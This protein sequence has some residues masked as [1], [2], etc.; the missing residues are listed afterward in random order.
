MSNGNPIP[1]SR[2]KVIQLNQIRE[3]PSAL[4]PVN[5]KSEKYE[6]LVD[7]VRKNGIMNPIVVREVKDRN[8]GEIYYGLVDG[9]H[10]YNAAQ[11][12]GLTEVAVNV[13]DIDEAEVLE[14]QILANLH[15]VDTRPVEYTKQLMRILSSNLLM[16]ISE[17]ASKLSVNP[18][19][20][21]ER[22]GLIKL[23]E[24]IANLV[25]E[26]KITLSNSYSLARLPFEEQSAYV[27]RAMTMQ[28]KEFIPT[29]NARVKEIRNAKRQG[30]DPSAQ[31]FVP[32]PHMRRIGEINE[33]LEKK[34]VVRALI[35]EVKPKTAEDAFMLGL[36]WVRH[37]DPLSIEAQK[38]ADADRKAKEEQDKAERKRKREEE[39]AEKAREIAETVTL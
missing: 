39:K 38:Q 4:R 30:R 11:D 25:D 37:M 27:E 23:D 7:S 18:G 31:T 28:P 8:T 24:K 5:K 36:E 19:W 3:N 29:V 34:A 17:L 33:E 10:R 12:A 13:I 2:P 6:G 14:A 15:K 1:K 20:L 9:L 16:T 35:A 32:V 26:G 21:S 22:L